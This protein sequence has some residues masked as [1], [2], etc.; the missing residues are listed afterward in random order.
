LQEL[1]RYG[2]A[3]ASYDRALSLRPDYAEALHNRSVALLDLQRYEDAIA[4]FAQLLEIAPDF[5]Y[6]M[7]KSCFLAISVLRL[8]KL[9]R[10]C[11]KSFQCSAR[12]KTGM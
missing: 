6:A 10:R 7:G 1:R 12:R 2:E 8:D 11:G 3:L 9:P 4:S 5:G